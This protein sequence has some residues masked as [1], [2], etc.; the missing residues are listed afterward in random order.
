MSKKVVFNRVLGILLTISIVAG[1]IVIASPV[2]QKNTSATRYA[3]FYTYASDYDVLFLGSDHVQRGIIPMELWRYNGITSYNLGITDCRMGSAYWILKNAL[4]YSKPKLVVVDCAYLGEEIVSANPEN[5]HEFLDDMRH[6]PTK[7]NAVLDLFSSTEDRIRYLLPFSVYHDRWDELTDKDFTPVQG[8]SK[9]G[10]SG[11][12]SLKTIQHANYTPT[13]T[14][15]L[16]N[17][18]INYLRRIIA[19]CKEQRIQ[20]LLTH[21]P[22]MDNEQSLQEAAFVQTIADEYAVNYLG[23]NELLDVLDTVTDF[24]EDQPNNAHLNMSGAQKLSRFLGNYIAKVYHLSNR[25]GDE[26]VSHWHKLCISYLYNYR[27][28]LAAQRKWYESLML[29]N[30]PNL[31][32]IIELHDLSALQD[33]ML[34]RFLYNMGVD[35]R[36]MIPGTDCI[37]IGKG[38]EERAYL[39]NF[40]QHSQSASTFLGKLAVTTDENG[41]RTLSADGAVLD[42]VENTEGIENTIRFI[43]MDDRN[44]EVI[45]R[46]SFQLS[47]ILGREAN[48]EKNVE[49][50]PR[51]DDLG[52]MEL[53]SAHGQ[54]TPVAVQSIDAF[55]DP[56]LLY[57]LPDGEV[58]SHLFMEEG[59]PS[60]T[61]DL[62]AGGY[63]SFNEWHPAGTPVENE[64][65]S[66]KKT[67]LLPVTPG[68]Q[69]LYRGMGASSAD[70]VVWLDEN[71]VYLSD[72][73]YDALEEPVL[74]T[75]PA[76]AAYACFAS[77]QYTTR[78]EKVVLEVEWVRCQNAVQWYEW[79]NTGYQYL[80]NTP[81]AEN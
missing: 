17:D 27:Y 24:A 31:Y 63:W 57:V 41:R 61:F 15:P 19:E 13:E 72:A 26:S 20:V 47:D 11:L 9:M 5:N 64:V 81:A 45:G 16:K 73:Q 23:L 32:L 30:N 77:F 28:T 60:I 12:T 48:N 51:F 79:V 4:E 80:G 53:L 67:N 21:I 71:M 22:F 54:K 44:N 18:N 70:S 43:A 37:V 36:S 65:T 52:L 76:G 39:S 75:V 49:L 38:G 34:T 8:E 74:I 1:F 2:V 58:Y 42:T 29:L 33:P 25:R 3:E 78:P 40:W 55:Q 35:Y 62:H 10:F 14:E 68:D 56:D 59:K 50:Q 7:V 66:G 6:F 46:Y 69:F